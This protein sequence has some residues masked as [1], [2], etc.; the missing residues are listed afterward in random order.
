MA[1]Y[2]VGELYQHLHRDVMR[3]PVPTAGVA[4]KKRQLW[5]GAMRL[6]YRILLEKGLKMMDGTVAL[7]ERTGEQSPWIARA[8]AAKHELEETLAAERDA[9]SKLP[10]SEEEL[11]AALDSLKAP[12]SAAAKR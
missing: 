8:R 6:R 12:A 7:S 10:Y 3:A 11:R 1:G 5:E 2:R 4:A 9:L